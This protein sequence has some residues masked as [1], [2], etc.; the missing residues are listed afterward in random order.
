MAATRLACAWTRTAER[1][2]AASFRA[3]T[4]RETRCSVTAAFRAFASRSRCKLRR[5]WACR[6]VTLRRFSTSVRTA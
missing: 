4:P 3:L 1:R 6:R 5:T 2:H